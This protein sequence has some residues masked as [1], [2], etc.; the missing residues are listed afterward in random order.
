MNLLF[1][2]N[3]SIAFQS[4]AFF[5]ALTLIVKDLRD[6]GEKSQD[7]VNKF[8]VRVDKCIYEH[9]GILTNA[10]V[11]NGYD[12]AA[13]AV[14]SLTRGNVLN[15]AQFNKFLEKH[16][17]ADKLSLYNLE[18]KGWIDPSNARVGGAFSEIMHKLYIGSLFLF[19]R[20]FTPEETAAV[21]LHEVGHAY[22]FLQFLADSIVVNVVMQRT[23]AELTNGQPDK[24]VKLILTKAAKDMGM[25]G[26][27]WLQP[28]EDTTSADVA[29]KILASAVQI[30]PRR[31]D[32]KRYFSMDTAEEL[33]DIFAARHGA[34]RAIVTMRSKFVS[35]N[36]KSYGILVGL[37]WAFAGLL[38]TP[39]LGPVGVGLMLGG[40]WLTYQG[41]AEA[42]REPD[43]TTFKQNATKMRNQFVEK[44]KLMD[45]P[46]EELVEEIASIEL[47]D[48]II[49]TYAGDFDTPTIVKFIDMFRRGK[50]DARAS[51]EYTDRLESL[52]ANDLFVRAAQLGTR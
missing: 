34:G 38:A 21:I 2:G 1:L 44:I 27:E 39:L 12:N 32:N 22:T 29:I 40:G 42:A 16:F 25:E 45:L 50:M 37:A 46:K 30:E 19:T 14:P 6:S 49:Q 36:G 8:C 31:M 15:R 10:L 17:D 13:V 33:A 28:V 3:E 51:R 47:T 20:T 18:Q 41:A 23:W 5:K 48:K 9:T 52:A 24:K 26:V 7:A 35:V 4:D 11:L 43:A